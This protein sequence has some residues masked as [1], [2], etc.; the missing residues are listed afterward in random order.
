[1]IKKKTMTVLLGII[2]IL[3][4]LFISI[5]YYLSAPIYQGSKTDHFDGQTF[6]NPGGVKANGLGKVL[7]WMITRKQGE[8]KEQFDLPPG[9]KPEAR[10]NPKVRVTFVNHSTFLIQADKL[11]ILTDPVWSE[12]TSPFT[13]AGP[14]RMRAPG[15]RYEDLP[16]IDVI[17]L[18]HNHYDHLDVPT[19]QRLVKDHKPII[20]TPLGVKAFLDQEEI[21]GAQ[22]TD[23]WDVITINDSVSVQSVP[24][25]HFSGRGAFDRDKTLW[26]GYVIKHSKGNLYFAGDTGYNHTTFKEIGERCSPIHLSILPI[27][28][29]KPNW[30]MSP[31]H[32]SP[33]DAVKIFLDI[34]TDFAIASHF[35]TFPL[36]DDGAEEPVQDLVKAL[37]RENISPDLFIALKEGSFKDF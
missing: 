30:F 3:I 29:Y 32:T 11:N 26:C 31:I 34:K 9:E 17:L 10:L 22:D 4:V 19:L 36:A 35:G 23:W 8:W 13:W 5:G 15:I 37:A 33:E 24:A 12:R 21:N 27:G 18:S 2:A 20:V 7:Q 25:Q 1:M 6:V 28:A 14:K 16:P